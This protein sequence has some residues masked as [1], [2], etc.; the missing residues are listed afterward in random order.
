MTPLL[1]NRREASVNP[2]PPVLRAI[3]PRETHMNSLR[4]AKRFLLPLLGLWIL[5]YGSV[6]LI[7]PPLLDGGDAIHAEAAREMALSGDW[8]TPHVNGIR[9]L[10]KSPLLYWSTALSFRLFGV[11]D[12]AARLPLAFYALA[13]F[14]LTLALGSRLF[15]TPVAGFYAALMLLTS[16][17]IFLFGHILFPD[18]LLTLWITLALYFFWRSLHHEKASLMTAVGFA[19]AC[20][21]GVLSKGLIGVIFPVVIVLLFLFF[22]RNLRHL[23]RWHPVPAILLFLLIAL[24]WHIAVGYTNPAQGHPSGL[25][26][27]PGNVHGFWWIYF[28]NEQVLRYFNQRV[29]HDYPNT[30]ILYFW[31]FLL[32]WIVP[33][34]FFLVVSVAQLP[35]TIF[36]RTAALE[37]VEQAQLL[38]VLWTL[39]VLLFFTFSTRQSFYLLPALPALTL[40]A[41]GWLAEDEASPSRA[42]Q[43]IAWIFFV[44]GIVAALAAV[45]LAF[46]VPMPRPGTDIGT[47]LNLPLR[48]HRYFFGH[49]ADL[50]LAA[51][52]AVR[53]PLLITAAALVAGVTGNLIFRRRNKIR[54]ANCFLAGMMVFILIAAHVALNTFSP[55][56]SSAILAE[57]IKPEV[58]SG[59]AIVINGRYEDASAMG[60]YLEH[61]LR[62][63][64]GRDGDLWYGSFFS[65]APAAFE[66]NAS[67]AK[68]WNGPGRVF[69]WT[70]PENMP[71]LNGPVYL[72][73]RNGGRE[74]VSNEPNN[75][76]ATF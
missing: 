52:G 60:F 44:I 34:C 67:L 16:C 45:V 22:T 13:L 24:P 19:V 9:Y 66:D 17:G 15:L 31:A 59:D 12:W 43:I 8:I 64:N 55:L 70:K 57:A 33:W 63:L 54:L 73:G 3:L 11:S 50:T 74:V 21:L 65:D 39:V 38:L 36:R 30:P 29:P 10:E 40:L 27:T 47:L 49:L 48:E 5:L 1:Y 71:A 53:V 14:G 4:T 37:C 23:L 26:P 61:P 18:L 68:L 46:R 35:R 25:T 69:L 51:M 62:M 2:A 28:F 56:V 7:K 41:A 42:A 20:A 72:I 75:G 32:L 76:G 58:G 6:S